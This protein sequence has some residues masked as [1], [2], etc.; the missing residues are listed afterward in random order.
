MGDIR[1]ELSNEAPSEQSPYEES[2]EK[3]VSRRDAPTSDEWKGE[4]RIEEIIEELQGR[5]LNQVVASA[6][7]R[8]RAGLR[9][10]VSMH[11]GCAVVEIVKSRLIDAMI[12][13]RRRGSIRSWR[14]F[15]GA[16][17]DHATRCDLMRRG[18]RPGDVFGAHR[19]ASLA[20]MEVV[21][22]G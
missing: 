20:K 13:G 12:D 7:W 4:D 10:L 3:S 22:H 17:E 15:I 11:G 19:R 8:D 1:N 18:E 14:Y 16:L 21:A 9:E 2:V 6:A 5:D